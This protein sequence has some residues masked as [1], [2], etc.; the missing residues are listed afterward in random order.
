[1]LRACSPELAA[2][3]RS[4]LRR[5][6]DYQAAGKPVCDWDDPQAREQLV[7]ALF[8]DGYR[9]LDALRG[10]TLGPE[11]AHAVALLATVI[12]QDIQETADG[13]FVIA[14]G[15]APDRV[16]SVVDPQARHRHKSN[17]RGFDGYK[18]H[19][20]IDP[21]SEVITAAAIG[22]ANTGDAA[23]APALLADLPNASAPPAADLAAGA[24]PTSQL[25]PVVYG[26]AAYGAGALLAELEQR[27]ITAMIKVAA[28]T[29]PTG[30]FPKDRFEIDL[31]AGTITCPARLKV[32]IIAARQGAPSS[33]KRSRHRLSLQHH[34]GT[35][36]RQALPPRVPGADDLAA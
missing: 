29:A 28:P 19:V 23:M 34:V 32:P 12:G 2:P 20:A 8:R 25:A 22:A 36:S 31:A 15:V 7:D 10:R 27:G 6:D 5:D 35:G 9:A 13:R 33:G 17:A 26:D 21:D 18:G 11:V 1:V 3:V 24:A 16:I 4:A 30:H 14:E